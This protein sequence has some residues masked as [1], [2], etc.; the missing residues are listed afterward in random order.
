MEYFRSTSISS[1]S[2]ESKERNNPMRSF[3][4][5]VLLG[6]FVFSPLGAVESNASI[7]LKELKTRT[8]LES[9]R[10]EFYKK[11]NPKKYSN[12]DH[13][14]GK[15]LDPFDNRFYHKLRRHTRFHSS[16]PPVIQNHIKTQ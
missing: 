3:I 1:N 10:Q 5:T 7:P 13:F 6:V 2:H 8:T 4:M 16:L 9:A 12:G 11:K 14:K 15:R